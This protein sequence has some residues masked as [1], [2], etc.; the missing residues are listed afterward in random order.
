MQRAISFSTAYDSPRG[1]L[2]TVASSILSNTIVG[3]GSTV[4]NSRL[5]TS[6][7]GDG[8]TIDGATGQL[9][10][11]DHSVVKIEG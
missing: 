4:T 8:A 2:L 5:T 1:A 9:N 10:V 6:M 3:T 7:V 11:S